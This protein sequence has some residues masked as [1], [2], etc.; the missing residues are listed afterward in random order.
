MNKNISMKELL[1]EWRQVLTEGVKGWAAR[2]E[3][4]AAYWLISFHEIL[5][6]NAPESSPIL[7]Q[8]EKLGQDALSM[9]SPVEE[10]DIPEYEVE[11][12]QALWADIPQKMEKQVNDWLK[13]LAPERIV[14]GLNA[15]INETP[16]FSSLSSAVSSIVRD[17]KLKE[18]I[19]AAA[20]GAG[21][22]KAAIRSRQ[23]MTDFLDNPHRFD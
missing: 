10:L 22:D 20:A 13:Q 12:Y 18:L 14:A 9:T 11:D 1:T 16:G 3:M 21:A 23:D 8:L 15:K 4:E 17:P 2:R 6:A 7:N 19:A 5:A